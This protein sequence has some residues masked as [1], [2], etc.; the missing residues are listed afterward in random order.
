M[1]AMFHLGGPEIGIGFKR[2][3]GSE[4]PP[5]LAPPLSEEVRGGSG[6][7]QEFLEFY[8][9]NDEILKSEIKF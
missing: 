8:F 6:F 4:S 7:D 2:W 3:G 5:F 1:A 9:L